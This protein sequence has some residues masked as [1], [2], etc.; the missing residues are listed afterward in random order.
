MLPLQGTQ[1]QSLVGKLKSCMPLC[2]TE[3]K[4]IGGF[5]VWQNPTSDLSFLTGS[6]SGG[7]VFV[8]PSPFSSPKWRV[9]FVILEFLIYLLPDVH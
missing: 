1:V 9:C 7:F 4:I 2:V 8:F 6:V 3:K 5:R